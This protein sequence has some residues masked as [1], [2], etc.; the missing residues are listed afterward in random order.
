MRPLIALLAVSASTAPAAPVNDDIRHYIRANSDGSRPEHVVH[1]RPSAD[2]IAVYKWVEK[3]ATA[4]YVTATLDSR[5]WEPRSLTAGKVARDGGQAAFGRIDADLATGRL[6][7]RMDGDPPVTASATVPR[8]LPWFLFD[9][10]LVDLNSWTQQRRPAAAFDFFWALVW[11]EGATLLAPMARVHATPTGLERRQGIRTRRFALTLSGPQD[12]RGTLWLDARS[13]A[14][15]EARV[16]RPNHPGMKDF[17]LTLTR[18]ERGGAA[19][20]GRLL[21]AHYAGCRAGG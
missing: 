5:T 11:P 1:F 16:S 8:G 21:R 14:I 13:G 9:Y 20:W 17:R 6:S 2:R 4:A 18:V 7:L 12:G 10:D 3:C 15:V 19:A